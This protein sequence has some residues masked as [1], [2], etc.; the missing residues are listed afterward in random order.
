MIIYRSDVTNEQ[1]IN[2]S[3]VRSYDKEEFLSEF[4]LSLLD[5]TKSQ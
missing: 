1:W 2:T 3:Y 4:S 5:A